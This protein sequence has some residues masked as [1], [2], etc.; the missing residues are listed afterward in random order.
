MEEQ[1]GGGREE[2]VESEWT[3]EGSPMSA[4]LNVLYSAEMSEDDLPRAKIYAIIKKRLVKVAWT[5]DSIANFVES[6]AGLLPRRPESWLFCTPF[7]KRSKWQ[8]I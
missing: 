6:E 3:I 2:E 7:V 1:E 8:E 5:F 4:E